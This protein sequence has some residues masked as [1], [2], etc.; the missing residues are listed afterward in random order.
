MSIFIR[1]IEAITEVSL[2]PLIK[3]ITEVYCYSDP[4]VGMYVEPTQNKLCSGMFA[5]GFF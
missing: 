3:D 1:M 5:R 4:Q 2:C